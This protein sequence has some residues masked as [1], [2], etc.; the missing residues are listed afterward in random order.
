MSRAPAKNAVNSRGRFTVE[1]VLANMWVRA[2]AAA[3]QTQGRARW[4]AFG[5][6]LQLNSVV[7]PGR[8]P[9]TSSFDG[10]AWML[11][12]GTT[13]PS[14]RT[15]RD[16]RRSA[17]HYGS[18]TAPE[19]Q[20]RD[21]VSMTCGLDGRRQKSWCARE[22]W[23]DAGSAE[24]SRDAIVYIVHDAA[25]RR[26]SARPFRIGSRR[27]VISRLTAVRSRRPGRYRP[28][29]GPSSSIQRRREIQQQDT[30]KA[31]MLQRTAP[32][33]SVRLRPGRKLR[34]RGGSTKLCTRASPAPSW[35]PVALQ[36]PG[37]I[38]D[39]IKTLLGRGR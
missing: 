9:F 37:A 4:R 29:N 16:P 18:P 26:W 36:G 30:E 8:W 20:R 33:P 10:P 24:L 39:S 14:V 32:R 34:D 19:R 28:T 38:V 25:A 6:P 1:D 11:S 15:L 3:H 5:W 22:F 35:W 2:R 21:P 17:F 27:T 13:N 31:E 12:S 7:G 23:I